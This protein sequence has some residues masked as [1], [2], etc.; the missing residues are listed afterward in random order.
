ML[1]YLFCE[2]TVVKFDSLFLRK[3]T[4]CD[5]GGEVVFNVETTS[6]KS[7]Q[8]LYFFDLIDSDVVKYGAANKYE[9]ADSEAWTTLTQ[10]QKAL[11]IT[12]TG[13]INVLVIPSESHTLLAR[14][15]STST[16]NC[17]Q[18]TI[19]T[20]KNYF[21]LSENMDFLTRFPSTICVLFM[22]SDGKAA[23]KNTLGSSSLYY[24]YRTSSSAL[25]TREIRNSATTTLTAGNSPIYLKMKI[26]SSSKNLD[27]N[28]IESSISLPEYLFSD[29]DVV[30][31][32]VTYP[33]PDRAKTPLPTPTQSPS[34]SPSMSPLPTRSRSPARTASPTP[35][36]SPTQS[37]SPT[38]MPTQSIL[39]TLSATPYVPTPES[40]PNI[41]E[42]TSQTQISNET[43]E[44]QN[45]EPS[46]T[47]ENTEATPHVEPQISNSDITSN[48]P[49]ATWN[50]LWADHPYVIIRGN[51]IPQIQE[52]HP[53]IPT[54]YKRKSLPQ[55][56]NAIFVSIGVVCCVVLVFK[57]VIDFIDYKYIH[58]DQFDE[59]SCTNNDDDTSWMYSSAYVYTETD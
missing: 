5:P 45:T 6:S 23:I 29:T 33:F 54:K 59:A 13:E 15:G 14:G 39:P 41:P 30:N 55:P 27:F 50:G 17:P 10:E 35:E 58:T 32:Y 3:S 1:L 42:T 38:L 49:R 8:Y 24:F 26:T 2:R 18:G 37:P 11:P 47:K 20:S 22:Q 53:P 46:D 36:R 31:E 40:T 4:Q 57:I 12:N 44:S 25:S 9:P 43:E 16:V 56:A 52:Y 7:V 34:A 51:D 19:F 21:S 28:I 48:T